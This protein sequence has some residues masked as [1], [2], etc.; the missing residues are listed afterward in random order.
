M[1]AKKNLGQNF[2]VDERAISKIV[3]AV[4]ARVGETIIEIGPGHGALT[5]RL[6]EQE[7]RLVAVEF[8]REIVPLLREEFKARANFMLIEGDALATDFCALIQPATHAR[9][10]ANLPYYI[11]TAIL[12]HLI[13]QRAC[14]SEMI[15]MLQREV[16]ERIAAPPGSSERGYLSVLI[17]AYCETEILFDVAPSAFRPAPKVWSTVVRLHIRPRAAIERIDEILLWEIVSAGFAQRR[18][19]IFNNM[20]HAPRNLLMR[21]EERGGVSVV[22]EAARIDPQRRAET[23]TLEEWA[24][25]T[26]ALE[27]TYV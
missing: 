23:L 21:I 18:K 1:R 3:A 5:A 14:V 11:S 12:Q 15:L 8:D 24:R 13:K 9:V 19:T 2:L 25:L 26:H 6:L 4:A 17:E 10:V 20:R 7:C 22:L 16:A 27:R